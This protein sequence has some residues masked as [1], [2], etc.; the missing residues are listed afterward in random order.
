MPNNPI[1]PNNFFFDLN[2]SMCFLFE[3]VII[4]SLKALQWL[5]QTEQS[6]YTLSTP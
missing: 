5:L 2:V 6:Q 4:G 3:P 1:V